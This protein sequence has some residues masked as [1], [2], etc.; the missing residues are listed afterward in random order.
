M[1]ILYVSQYFPPELC[2]PA[3][4][5]H[6]LAKE[7]TR[8]GHRVTVL[9]AFAHHPLGVKAPEDRRVLTRRE[10]VDGINVVRT[11]VYASPNQGTGKR[12]LSYTS[13][14]IS[15]TVLGLFRV[16]RPDVVIATSPQLLCA[17]AGYL[18][19]RLMRVPFVFEVRDLWPEQMIAVK[20]MKGE[21]PV[22]RGLRVV[23][24]TLYKRC[25]RIVTVGAGYAKWIR[26]LY[27]IDRSKISIVPN[28]TDISRFTPACRE[29]AVR[30]E[31]GWSDKFVWM[32]LG[33]HGMSHGLH[34]VVEVARKLQ[35]DETQLF[36]FVGEGAEKARLHLIDKE[37]NAT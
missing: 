4:R 25:D 27:G 22:I 3:T 26:D 11:Y 7:W 10:S 1:Q 34:S 18:L 20:I 31:Y 15:A 23:A 30:E 24:R 35:D 37:K 2:A 13:F 6:D 5:V 14:M 32:Y 16:R 29:N 28:G 33:T 8:Q 12:M 19:A 9:T 36:V 21:N 17:C